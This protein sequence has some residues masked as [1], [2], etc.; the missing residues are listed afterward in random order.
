MTLFIILALACIFTHF[1]QWVCLF[2]TSRVLAENGKFLRQALDF[3]LQKGNGFGHA[4]NN[5]DQQEDCQQIEE[6][7]WG[8][9]T[10]QVGQPYEEAIPDGK[11]NQHQ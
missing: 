7:D 1:S 4:V 9:N 8:C 11:K 2:T 3:F 5:P 6:V 10:N